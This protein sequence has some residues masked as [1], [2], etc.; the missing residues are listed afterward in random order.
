[1]KVG[2]ARFM[3]LLL[4]VALRAHAVTVKLGVADTSSTVVM[5]V[6]DRLRIELP[7]TPAAG[8]RWTVKSV[9]ASHLEHVGKDIQP[10][11]AKHTSA[12][13]Q[14]FVWKALSPGKAELLLS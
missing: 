10:E 4:L 1:M 9:D 8:F 7:T 6:G 11:T 2:K 14:V 13:T 12:G 5:H 3:A